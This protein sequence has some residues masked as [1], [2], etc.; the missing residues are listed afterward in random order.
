MQ[1]AFVQFPK[2]LKRRI[3]HKLFL[4][5]LFCFTFYISRMLTASKCMQMILAVLLVY[6]VRA[7]A[8]HPDLAYMQSR[9]PL[10][11]HHLGDRS[12]DGQG[13]SSD[14]AAPVRK[15]GKSKIFSL[16]NRVS[17]IFPLA[18][19]FL[20]KVMQNVTQNERK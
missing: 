10:Q 1:H 9:F 14:P 11:M 20:C 19:A 17:P 13:T 3:P 4:I 7:Y 6:V 12:I 15:D 5:S 8:Y 16:Q 2:N 18:N